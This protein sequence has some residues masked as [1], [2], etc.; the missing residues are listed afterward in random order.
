MQYLTS[1][2]RDIMITQKIQKLINKSTCRN[3]G[4]I[5]GLFIIVNSIAISQERFIKPG[6]IIEILAP[7]TKGLSQ[8]V[9]V[10]QD[11]SVDYPGLSG[12]PVDGITIRRFQEIL[13]AQLARFSKETPLIMV[14]FCESYPMRI[15]V[16]GQVA[17]PGL[18]IVANSS[19]IQGAIGSAGGFL[20]GAELSHIKLIRTENGKE[21]T[22]VVNMENFFLKGDPSSLPD[23]KEW[24]TI[25]V[26]GNPL[27]TKV[28]VIGAVRNPGSYDVFFKTTVL[29][30]VFLAGGPLD[31]ANLGK[32]QVISFTEK[33]TKGQRVNL[34][35]ITKTKNF[36]DIGVVQPG[37]IVYIPKKIMTWGK[38][39]NF[40]RDL[41]TF[42]TLYL[43]I[44][45]E[46]NR[47]G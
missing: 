29:D 21:I 33:D 23:L 13:I 8:V 36:K 37:D 31:D 44:R 39:I 24:D 14:R 2:S 5:I 12:L 16:L 9:I 35:H 34:K 18:Y 10:N 40:M 22:Q 45:W 27:T 15:N 38:L 11:G 25:I 46:G 7:E 32:V 20:P 26:P 19:T 47:K 1:T 6:D 43:V 30:V 41:S 28:K 42:A 4:I 3:L 17:K